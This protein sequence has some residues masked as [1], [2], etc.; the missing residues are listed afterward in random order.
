MSNPFQ[1]YKKNTQNFKIYN[2]FSKIFH[3]I[4]SSTLT[5][6]TIEL[7][8]KRTEIMNDSFLSPVHN[9]SINIPIGSSFFHFSWIHIRTHKTL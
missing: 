9:P 7:Q 8:F 1:R 2:F 6:L 4:S 5:F 3:T